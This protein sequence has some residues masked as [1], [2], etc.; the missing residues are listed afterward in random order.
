MDAFE[1]HQCVCK[2]C[3]KQVGKLNEIYGEIARGTIVTLDT[4]P[5]GID[6]AKSIPVGKFVRLSDV[7]AILQKFINSSQAVS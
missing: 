3:G 2:E 6:K 1:K 5:K 4:E 7:R